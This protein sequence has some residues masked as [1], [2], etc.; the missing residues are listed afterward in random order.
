VTEALKAEGFG[1]LTEIDVQA[2]NA[3]ER[4]R[5][6]P[7]YDLDDIRQ[8][9]EQVAIRMAQRSRKRCLAGN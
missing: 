7:R 2:T 6:K 9:V 8:Q 1:M 3:S 5:S 4:G